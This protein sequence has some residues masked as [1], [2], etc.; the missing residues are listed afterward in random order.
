MDNVHDHGVA[1][2]PDAVLLDQD[3]QIVGMTGRHWV[4]AK[5]IYDALDALIAPN[6]C[7]GGRS[8]TQIE[9][10]Y[11][12]GGLA[13]TESGSRQEVSKKLFK[14]SL[15]MKPHAEWILPYHIFRK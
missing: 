7:R 6:G 8:E 11:G 12:A 4:S 13:G 3:F 1:D 2:F 15:A 5:I 10:G 9:N 14:L